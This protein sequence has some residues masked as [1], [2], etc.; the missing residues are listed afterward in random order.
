LTQKDPDVL[1][2]HTRCFIC[3]Y[4]VRCRDEKV[5]RGSKKCVNLLK[6]HKK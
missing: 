2:W 5:A 6:H 4:R 1:K 3:H